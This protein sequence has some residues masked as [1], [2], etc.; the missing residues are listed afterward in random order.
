MTYWIVFSL[1][2]LTEEVTDMFFSFWFPLYYEC[3]ILILAWLIS[4]A[5]MGSTFLYRQIIHPTLINRE[6]EIDEFVQ[7][8]K[9]QSYSLGLK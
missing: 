8:W 6:D 5:T 2:T 4:P 3:K 9:E 1:L 7:K